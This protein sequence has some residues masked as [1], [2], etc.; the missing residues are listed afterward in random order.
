M[1]AKHPPPP[2]PL[3]MDAAPVTPEVSANWFSVLT[4]NWISPMMALGAARTLEPE[5]LYRMDDARSA[6]RI[7]ARMMGFYEKRKAKAE[8]YN[9]RLADP[10]QPLPFP[11]RITYPLLPHRAEREKDFRTNRGRKKPHLVLAL[12]DT[13][14]WYF[15]SAGIIK[16][17]GDTATACSTLLI[18]ALIKWATQWEYAHKGVAGIEYPAVGNGVGLAIGLFAILTFGSFCLH[19]Y[20]V[21]SMGVG[22][23]TRSALIAAIYQHALQLTQKA[24]G[25]HPNGKIVNHISTDTSRIDFAAGFAHIAWTSP[26]QFIVISIILLV[27][28]GYSALPG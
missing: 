27:Q 19:H 25:E 2:A 17:F 1:K 3:S 21:R 28:I 24:R 26:V 5:D 7:S 9:A 23:L 15:W 16:L 18:R 8:A 6:G 4:F 10:A 14:G 12:S 13:F 11:Q 20:F 22:V